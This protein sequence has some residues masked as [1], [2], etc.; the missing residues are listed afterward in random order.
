MQM[1]KRSCN[2]DIQKEIPQPVD[3]KTEISKTATVVLESNLKHS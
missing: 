2:E 3:K 1:N